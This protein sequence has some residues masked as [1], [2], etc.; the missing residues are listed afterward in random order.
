MADKVKNIIYAAFFICKF[1]A[2]LHEEL[3]AVS[4]CDEQQ[5]YDNMS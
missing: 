2:G 3:N 1:E 4:N 5:V